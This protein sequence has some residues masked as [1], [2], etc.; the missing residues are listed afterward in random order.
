MTEQ[1][2]E[3]VS[4]LGG[5]PAG[6]YAG[7]YLKDGGVPFT[8]YEAK[9]RIGGNCVT[10]RHGDFYFDSGAHRL[11]DKDRTITDAVANLLGEDLLRTST[12]S[13]ILYRGR[14][15]DFPLTPF[16]LVRHLGLTGTIRS[17]AEVM[18]S[19]LKGDGQSWANFEDFAV[20][21]YGRTVA[22]RFLLTYSEKLWGIPCIRISSSMARTR[23]KGLN[24]R[25]FL[26]ETV[27]ARDDRVEHFEGA[28]YYPKYGIGMI[29]DKLGEICGRESIRTNAGI[30]RISHDNC[31]FRTLTI[32]ETEEIAVED[33]IS[34]L[35]LPYFL[36]VMDPQPDGD[37][38]ALADSLHYRSLILVA[39][40]LNR[41]RIS[42]NATTYFPEARFVF[43]R[44]YEPKNRSPFMS[45]QGKTSLVVEIACDAGDDHWRMDDDRLTSL[46]LSHLSEVGWVKTDEIIDSEVRRMEYAYPVLQVGTEEKTRRMLDYLAGFENLKVTGR[47]ACFAYTSIHEVLR[48]TMEVM[49]GQSVSS[50][51]ACIAGPG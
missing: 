40:F 42:P 47:N 43:S 5:G 14:F 8:V 9:D 25:S 1:Q 32:N 39:F 36:R 4:I 22:E 34:T 28:F 16:S 27:R 48:S 46:V 38:L 50:R 11:H 21:T 23:L 17:A 15:I 35:P 7:Y 49:T 44:A 51:N 31:R 19:R 3:H 45:P 24:L 26:K 10:H 2:S 33:V 41:E 29:A 20:N 18:R 37:L 13:Q 12:P 30:T 6:L